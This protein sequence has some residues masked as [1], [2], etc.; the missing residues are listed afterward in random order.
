M[1][2]TLLSMTIDSARRSWPSFLT[3]TIASRI[4]GCAPDAAA[5]AMS[6]EEEGRA[7][8]RSR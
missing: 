4:D 3:V 5:P 2:N 6:G 8:I 1:Q 7:G